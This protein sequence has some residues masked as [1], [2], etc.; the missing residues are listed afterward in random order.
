[1]MIVV[2]RPRGEVGDVTI[3]RGKPRE[4]ASQRERQRA[5]GEVVARSGDLLE[6]PNPKSGY[7]VSNV[8][9][10]AGLPSSGGLVTIW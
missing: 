7:P 4:V 9:L 6:C 5:R 8:T 2:V 1:M 10:T 3:I